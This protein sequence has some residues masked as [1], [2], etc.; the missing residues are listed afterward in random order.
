MVAGMYSVIL[1]KR[2]KGVLP[3]VSKILFN[4]IGLLINVD[5]VK[6]G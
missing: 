1:F 6:L 5:F 4:H 3:M 2:I